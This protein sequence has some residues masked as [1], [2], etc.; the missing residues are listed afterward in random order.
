MSQGLADGVIIESGFVGRHD[1]LAAVL[2]DLDRA[3]RNGGVAS[4]VIQGDPGVGKTRLLAEVTE[5]SPIRAMVRAAAYE[6][7]D[8]VP[9]GVGSE[10]LRGLASL[11]GGT[12][13]DLAGLD[14]EPILTA[15][16]TALFERVNS[17][18]AAAGPLVIVVDDVQW[19]DEWSEA[20]LQYLARGATTAEECAVFLLAGRRSDVTARV[21]DFFGRLLGDRASRVSLGPLDRESAAALVAA[22]NPALDR[23]GIAEVI[24]RAGGSP[25]WCMLLAAGGDSAGD[26]EALVDGRLKGIGSDT[27]A[28]ATTLAVL[29]LLVTIE[30]LRQIHRWSRTRVEAAVRDLER[31][32]VV[33]GDD[34]TGWAVHDLARDA[35]S[36]RGGETLRRRAHLAIASWLERVGGDDA[37]S[38]VHAAVHR[39]AAGSA[40][41]APILRALTSSTRRSMGPAGLRTLL[42]LVEQTPA[43]PVDDVDLDRHLAVL[44][45]EL[46]QHPVALDRWLLVAAGPGGPADRARAWLA[47][48]EAAQRM[49]DLHEADACLRR[50]REIA[51]STDPVLAIELDIA[52][53]ALERWLKHRPD[54]SR[55]VTERAIGAL[56]SLYPLESD[57]N[58][59]DHRLR[60]AYVRLLTL[61]SLDAQQR[62][63]PD[64][65]ATI[66]DELS[67]VADGVDV[68]T[69]VDV[70]LRSGSALLLAGR[71]AEAERRLGAAYRQACRATLPDRIMDAGSWKV[72]ADYLGGRLSDADEVATSCLA[73]AARTEDGSRAAQLVRLYANK[74]A[75]SRVG[76]TEALRNLRA[77]VDEE[78]DPHFRIG[79]QLALSTFSARLDEDR[80]RDEVLERLDAARCDSV[81]AQCRR[82][83]SELLLMGAD[84]LARV[85]AA[86]RASEWLGDPAAASEDGSPL[87]RWR[88]S[89]ARASWA[90]AALRPEM[91]DLLDA[92]AS[93]ADELGLE[94]EAVW[95]R[96]DLGR[97]MGGKDV[98][99]A[100][101]ALQR[102]RDDAS[103]VGAETERQLADRE[104]RRLGQRTW[105]RGRS[106]AGFGALAALTEREREIAEV[107]AAGKSNPEIAEQL[108]ISRKTVERHVS[109]ILAKLDLRNRTELAAHLAATDDGGRSAAEPTS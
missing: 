101:Q 63:A 105:R 38:L 72:W 95:A 65:M 51:P 85:G 79:L 20:L 11:A 19:C 4:V 10:L 86:S 42:S 55:R 59:A 107:V 41:R 44:A 92:V 17:A 104:L 13:M 58:S 8:A 91:F 46:G 78:T 12:T 39:H 69:T 24:Q 50:A 80:A 36:R 3:A 60:R 64:E 29:D 102:A 56:R 93:E 35:V 6:N 25:F 106:G 68:A 84:A 43:N 74:I 28:L 7:S 97:L 2:A 53:A 77:M 22:R 31:R 34:S 103:R 62:N 108:F 90:V 26:V 66:A 47:G 89:R 48:C 96:L 67:R 57:W 87:Q 23:A 30:D 76:P 54:R 16:G 70:Q 75:V 81:V 98:V 45:E 88:S 61:S 33:V 73:L 52:E 71:L 5:R 1:E 9:Y 15:A 49:E 100:A 32:A 27:A 14:A 83:E 109:S 94:L 37:T 40:A 82:C 99:R 18:R 21:A